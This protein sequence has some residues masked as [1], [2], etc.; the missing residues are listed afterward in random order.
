MGSSDVENDSDILVERVVE[1]R[2][3][4]VFIVERGYRRHSRV[5][6]NPFLQAWLD[7]CRARSAATQVDH[8]DV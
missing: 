5:Q 7:V 1:V 6:P 2:A 4:G 8:A 3:E